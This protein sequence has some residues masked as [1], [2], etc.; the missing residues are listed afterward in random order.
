[1]IQYSLELTLHFMNPIKFTTRVEICL[2][3]SECKIMLEDEEKIHRNFL[4]LILSKKDMLIQNKVLLDLKMEQLEDLKK[5]KLANFPCKV[6]NKIVKLCLLDKHLALCVKTK[7]LFSSIF[8]M[9]IELKNMTSRAHMEKL[10]KENENKILLKEKIFKSVEKKPTL[11]SS[12]FGLMKTS[13]VNLGHLAAKVNP[14]RDSGDK[15]P[16]TLGGMQKSLTKPLGALSEKSRFFHLHRQGSTDSDETFDSQHQPQSESANNSFLQ[17]KINNIKQKELNQ[18]A[19]SPKS[20]DTSVNGKSIVPIKEEVGEDAC[21]PRNSG[22]MTVEIVNSKDNGQ[23]PPKEEKDVFSF[24]ENEKKEANEPEKEGENEDSDS[25]SESND[26]MKMIEGM[27]DEDKSENNEEESKE[28]PGIRSERGFN[29]QKE[30]QNQNVIPQGQNGF[31][32]KMEESPTER[33]SRE[34][35]TSKEDNEFT[36]MIS[37]LVGGGSFQSDEE[38]NGPKKTLS[39]DKSPF[40]CGE[41]IS[42]DLIP[43]KPKGEQSPKMLSLG[44]INSSSEDAGEIIKPKGFLMKQDSFKL[45]KTELVSGEN[46]PRYRLKSEDQKDKETRSPEASDNSNTKM[47]IF[48]KK[49]ND[50]SKEEGPKSDS[51]NDSQGD[52]SNDEFMNSIG[53]LLGMNEGDTSQGNEGIIARNSDKKIQCKSHLNQPET[54]ANSQM[55]SGREIEENDMNEDKHEENKEKDKN[56]DS[57]EEDGNFFTDFIDGLV[58]DNGSGSQS[59]SKGNTQENL[60]PEETKQEEEKPSS[61]KFSVMSMLKSR[62]ENRQKTMMSGGLKKYSTTEWGT[63]ILGRLGA[64][65][66][67]QEENDPRKQQLDNHIKFNYSVI[68]FYDC[69]SKYNEYLKKETASSINRSKS[70][71][72]RVG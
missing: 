22:Q 36:N 3:D 27:V 61:G 52:V 42:I 46:T 43:I 69:L 6:C 37:G 20:V 63:G 31:S 19:P 25:D 38:Q 51:K 24:K 62:Q 58:N 16:K 54:R 65:Q 4:K 10:V 23:K 56:K 50:V 66:A 64:K 7:E 67:N 5:R 9:N 44:K 40:G 60:V 30:S 15:K 70:Q 45:K 2:Y 59:H 72:G 21:S 68:A 55:L 32:A 26:F 14:M 34:E 49:K 39:M 41:Q 47:S 12:G 35:E 57:D 11:G 29:D 28:K 53:N 48:H 1:M 17:N 18:S 33:E 13:T 71:R 8:Q